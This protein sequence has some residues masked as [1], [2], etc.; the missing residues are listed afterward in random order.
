MLYLAGMAVSFAASAIPKYANSISYKIIL[1]LVERGTPASEIYLCRC[2]P[3]SPGFRARSGTHPRCS[4]DHLP[5]NKVRRRLPHVSMGRSSRRDVHTQHAPLPHCS[6]RLLPGR[7]LQNVWTIA[8]MGVPPEQC[9]YM[10]MIELPEDF[11]DN[12]NQNIQ[13]RGVGY[14]RHFQR[15]EN[16]SLVFDKCA[17]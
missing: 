16:M 15:K 7:H 13:L 6:R 8:L 12:L 10:Q 11:F 3:H 2:K 14:D 1:Y 17:R 9:M 5:R 4:S